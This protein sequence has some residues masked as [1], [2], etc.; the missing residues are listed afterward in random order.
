MRNDLRVY[1]GSKYM[2]D[3]VMKRLEAESDFLWQHGRSKPTYP[4]FTEDD[5]PL[6]L[7]LHNNNTLSWLNCT[8]EYH[9]DAWKFLSYY[10][11]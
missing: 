7:I 2:F 3:Y 4:L 11:Q 9:F 10:F 8:T 6:V 1:F 5:F